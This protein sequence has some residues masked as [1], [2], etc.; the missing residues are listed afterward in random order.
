M[1]FK[2]L[3]SLTIKNIELPYRYVRLPQ[4]LMLFQFVDTEFCGKANIKLKWDFH[5][6]MTFNERISQIF[7]KGITDTDTDVGGITD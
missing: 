2:L 4:K 6:K 7:T 1:R 3:I 5:I